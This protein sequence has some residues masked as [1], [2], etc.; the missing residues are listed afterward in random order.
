MAQFDFLT[1]YV[2]E[3]LKQN[4]LGNLSDE[5]K[6]AYVPQV[7]APV[8]QRLGLELLPSRKGLLYGHNSNQIVF[9]TS[10]RDVPAY[11]D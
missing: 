2:L 7:L 4:G 5:Q 10:E 8:E 11:L 3:L 6:N 9:R 1:E